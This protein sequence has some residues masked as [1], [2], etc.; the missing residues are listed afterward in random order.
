MGGGGRAAA[1]F[2][3]GYLPHFGGMQTGTVLKS[4]NNVESQKGL[5]LLLMTRERGGRRGGG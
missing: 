2:G 5:F 3:L 4:G 1:F